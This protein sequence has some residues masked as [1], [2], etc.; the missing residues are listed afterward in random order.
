MAGKGY[1][2]SATRY[3]QLTLLLALA[4]C[5]RTSQAR[6]ASPTARPDLP[7]SIR[8]VAWGLALQV[9]HDSSSRSR[10]YRVLI[11]PQAAPRDSGESAWLD[12]L[13]YPRHLVG[14]FCFAATPCECQRHSPAP[15]EYLTLSPPRVVGKDTLRVDV[16]HAATYL[17]GLSPSN[18][19]TGRL[20]W[21]IGYHPTVVF[22]A[23]QSTGWALI[24]TPPESQI[25]LIGDGYCE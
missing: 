16:G 7:D 12:S 2:V 1:S 17:F 4:A 25:S 23:R 22:L 10:S 8:R 15:A 21:G 19:S 9:G 13:L 20:F 11:I 18:L 5:G 3:F 14:G 6:V 24:P